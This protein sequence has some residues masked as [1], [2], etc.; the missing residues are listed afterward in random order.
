MLLKNFYNQIYE[1]EIHEKMMYYS[2]DI[3]FSEIKEY[4]ER[5]IAT[6]IEKFIE[7]INENCDTGIIRSSDIFQFSS[8]HHAT[9][10]VCKLLKECDNPGCRFLEIGKLLLNDG[11]ERNAGAL[12]KYGE[13]HA[14][15]AES[16]GLLFELHRTYFLSIYGYELLELAD[17]DK[18][19]LLTRLLLRNKFIVRLIKAS[20]NGNIEMRNFL[21]MLSDTT[22][23][24]R[25]SNI[26]AILNILRDSKEFD[27]SPFVNKIIL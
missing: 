14:K 2:Y 15:T 4:I 23:V 13:N 24:R 22:Y 19:K 5:I 27:F 6:D 1:K 9:V 16:L 20:N 10:E 7:Y 8:L 25:R 17:D 11:K 3:P 26:K 18:E 12:T 21:Y